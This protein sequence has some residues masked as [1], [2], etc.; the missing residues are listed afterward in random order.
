MTPTPP[1]ETRF[2]VSGEGLGVRRKG[3]GIGTL[4]R[5]F[6]FS[7]AAG[8]LPAAILFGYLPR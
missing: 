4:A 3:H 5:E 6:C 2:S 8:K 7:V 1:S